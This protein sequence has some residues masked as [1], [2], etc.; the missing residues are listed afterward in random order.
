MTLRWEQRVA[1]G[2]LSQRGVPL[3]TRLSAGLLLGRTR[4][5]RWGARAALV[6]AAFGI[7]LIAVPTI[8]VYILTHAI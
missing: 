5:E 8:A 2:F 3:A 7:A 1:A 4:L 6:T